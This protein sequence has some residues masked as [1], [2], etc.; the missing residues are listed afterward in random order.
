MRDDSHDSDT[1]RTEPGTAPR[2]AALR[3][4]QGYRV[5]HE[6][7]D[8]RGW[9]VVG[10][11]GLRIGEVNDLLVDTAAGKVCY[12]DIQLDPSLY[13]TGPDAAAP[14][15]GKIEE[16]MDERPQEPDVAGSPELDP[17][18]DAGMS[19]VIG[20]AVAP[21][22]VATPS[23]VGATTM[24]E[25]WVR[26]SISDEENALTADRHLDH[27]HHPGERHVV[28]PI[29]QAQLDDSQDRV[30]LASQRSE[31]AVNL[32][33]YVPGEI[34][35]DYEQGLRKWFDPSFTPSAGQDLYAHDLYDEE[36]FY[37]GRRAYREEASLPIRGR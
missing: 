22:P 34:S 10:G 15:E 37:Q 32:P 17:L 30:I 21:A 25:F 7:P 4:L 8:I 27:R 19:G 18:A 33:A 20:H 13:R 28:Y 26:E 1:D 36:R 5:A 35:P 9:E 6:D 23:L 11:D 2:I 3:N 12:L 16:K 29:G 14:T 24:T 31:D